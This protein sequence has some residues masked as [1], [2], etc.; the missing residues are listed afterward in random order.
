MQE[1]CAEIGGSKQV[2]VLVVSRKEASP[3]GRM[4]RYVRRPVED[5]HGSENPMVPSAVREAGMTDNARLG[6]FVRHGLRARPSAQGAGL[7]LRIPSIPIGR[8]MAL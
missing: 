2:P 1:R 6:E 3:N 7:S 4:A 5:S 8:P